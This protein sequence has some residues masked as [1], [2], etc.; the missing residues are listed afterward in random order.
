M[1]HCL[2]TDAA[3]VSEGLRCAHSSAKDIARRLGLEQARVVQAVD[4]LSAAKLIE[5][6]QRILPP[7]P[8]RTHG[9]ARRRRPQR[10]AHLLGR[11]SGRDRPEPCVRVLSNGSNCGVSWNNTDCSGPPRWTGASM[12]PARAECTCDLLSPCQ[13]IGNASQRIGFCVAP[14]AVQENCKQGRWRSFG[15]F[16][17]SGRL[18]QLLRHPRKEQAQRVVATGW[19]SEFAT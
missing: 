19:P 2:S 17:N 11:G 10:P 3:A 14:G 6:P 8:V 13:T 9:Q 5:E 16:K 18:R 12:R 1:A 4:E 15:M 7:R